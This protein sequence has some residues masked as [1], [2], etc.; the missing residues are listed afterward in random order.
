MPIPDLLT[1]PYTPVDTGR[2]SVVKALLFGL[3]VCLFIGVFTPFGLSGTSAGL[4][5]VALCYG[6]ATTG[7]MLV[8]HLLVPRII[9]AFFQPEHW[10]VGR[11]I[12]WTLDN[13]GAVVLVNL[14]VS[15]ALGL[16]P[17]TVG[18]AVQFTG[19]TL[20]VAVI[21]VVLMLLWNEHRLSRRF[22]QGSDK[23]NAS[24]VRPEE[25]D[26]G[27]TVSE[28]KPSGGTVTIPTEN[29][30]EDLV[31]PAEDLLFIRSAGNYLEVHVRAKGT[32]ERNVVRG[33]LRAVE[34]ALAD[35]PRFLRCH[36]SHLVNL[37]QVQRV[38][39]NAQGYK[40][41]LGDGVDPVPVSRSLNKRLEELLAART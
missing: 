26:P 4:W 12:A 32:T 23:V 30:K 27:P 37:G 41:H 36:K 8:F 11:M 1:R 3:F 22:R 39:G 13:V 10:T 17:L 7:V 33:S 6:L 18:S 34:A 29:G 24:M 40:L 15:H 14:W 28:A 35:R 31:L 38:S 9:P 16:M 2:A 21:P 5:R 25:R 19:Y 20:A